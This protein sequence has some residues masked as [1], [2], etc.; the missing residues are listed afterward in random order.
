MYASLRK[1]FRHRDF[2]SIADFT[3]EEIMGLL[4]FAAELKEAK[5]RGE[6]HTFCAGKS[7]AMIFQKPSTRTRVS[8]EVAM[9]DLGGYA[10]YLNAQDLQL[11]RGESIA[12]TG[13]ALSR[14]VDG[15]VIRTFRQEEVEELAEAATIPVINGLTSWEHPCQIL[16]DFLTILQ[17]KGRLAGL[18]LAYV[19]DGNNICHS[20]LLGC[21]RVGMSIYVATPPQ[22][23]PH[24]AVVARAQEAAQGTE[25]VVTEDPVQA[26][27]GADVVVTDVWVSMGQEEEAETKKKLFLP[28]QVNKELV[29]HAKPDF[30]FLHCLPAHR[31]EEVTAEVID[32]PH[33]LVWEEAENR[34]H[35]QKALLALLL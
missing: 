19:G 14:Y 33:S 17:S 21:P 30:I 4:S 34:L 28:Y 3:G 35:V 9:F 12:D 26:V 1:R 18:K 20:L 27:K 10:L 29:S 23:A 24:P 7:L 32:G 16:A 2:L 22:Y 31:G 6:T 8:F 5:K 13:R 11:G 25:V 15:C